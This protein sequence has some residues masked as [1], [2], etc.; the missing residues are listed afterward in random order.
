MSNPTKPPRLPMRRPVLPPPAPLLTKDGCCSDCSVQ[1]ML[2]GGGELK[3]C[4]QCHALLW[5]VD[6]S[7]EERRQR[8]LQPFT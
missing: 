5:H 6:W 7:A 2:A 1:A 3:V 8:H 4:P